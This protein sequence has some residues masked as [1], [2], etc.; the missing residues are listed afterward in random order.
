MTWKHKANKWCSENEANRLALPRVAT[1]FKFVKITVSANHNKSKCNKTRCAHTLKILRVT[2]KR[3]EYDLL[4]RKQQ[5]K[6]GEDVEISINI[7]KEKEEQRKGLVKR[8]Q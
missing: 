5:R 4:I 8:K 3:I 6:K 1:N 7:E 2:T